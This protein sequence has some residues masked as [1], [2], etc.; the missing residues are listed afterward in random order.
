MSQVII[1]TDKT[2]TRNIN[3]I[4]KIT[5]NKNLAYM[6]LLIMQFYP[7]QTTISAAVERSENNLSHPIRE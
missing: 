5:D 3:G 6:R 2:C 1:R 4:N 7:R